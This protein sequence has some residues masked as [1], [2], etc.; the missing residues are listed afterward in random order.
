MLSSAV[1][2]N[3]W[4][5]QGFYLLFPNLYVVLVGPPGRCAKSTAIRMGRQLLYTVPGVN[6]GPDSTTREELIKILSE[7]QS[8][9]QCS[10]T[11]HSTEL[12]SLLEP[13]GIP[14]IQFLTDIYD[15][16]YSNPKGWQYS[17]K[18][19]G[20]YEI[21]NPYLT[22]LAGTTPSYIAEGLPQKIIGHGFTARTMFI[23][24]E[25]E[26]FLNPRPKPPKKELVDA[27]RD[28]LVQISQIKGKFSWDKD[29]DEHY[30]TYYRSIGES[31]PPDHRVEGFHWRKHRTHIIKL[32]MLTSLS[33]RDDKIITLPDVKAAEDILEMIEPKMARTFQSV[34]KYE[35]ALDQ[36]RLLGQI[37]EAG[38]GG[39]SV[40]ELFRRNHFMGSLTALNEMLVGLEVMGVVRKEGAGL[41]EAIVFAVE[42]GRLGR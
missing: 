22:L 30:Q 14:M 16:E 18:G 20:R 13:S 39:I 28:D 7:S 23:Y 1:R 38:N 42:G 17:T 41:R 33:E 35:H 2:R 29:A 26:R 27:L 36:E 8:E 21:H 3:V 19:A 37:I 5:D 15:C 34:G 40:G 6:I 11:L 25:K 4:D 24:E 32:A 10:V 12:S 9:G 31:E